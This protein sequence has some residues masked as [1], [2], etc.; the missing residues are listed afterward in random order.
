M[1][2]YT[3]KD[4][5]H[6][7]ADH[8]EAEVKARKAL[9]EESVNAQHEADLAD[10][11][12]ETCKALRKADPQSDALQA[13]CSLVNALRAQSGSAHALLVLKS[14]DVTDA[15]LRLI[16]AED[17]LA[18]EEAAVDALLDDLMGGLR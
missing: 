13:A 4:L 12:M 9:A 15:K 3:V 14:D 11:A 8:K 16:W 5:R 18:V 2:N 7:V 17:A 1:S 6:A 10:L